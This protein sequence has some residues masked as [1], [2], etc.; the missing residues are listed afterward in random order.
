MRSDVHDKVKKAS[1]GDALL[2][3]CVLG[4]ENSRDYE[5]NIV[6]QVQFFPHSLFGIHNNLQF[7]IY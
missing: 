4:T 3:L 1:Q 2:M 5:M 7:K 6:T